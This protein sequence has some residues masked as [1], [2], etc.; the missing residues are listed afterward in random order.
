MRRKGLDEPPSHKRALESEYGSS[1]RHYTLDAIDWNAAVLEVVRAL[2]PVPVYPSH[3]LKDGAAKTHGRR[4]Q[5]EATDTEAWRREGIQRLNEELSRYCKLPEGQTR[6]ECPEMISKG[7]HDHNQ[8][9][10][11]FSLLT[12]SQC[13][14]MLS[15]L[16]DRMRYSSRESLFRSPT[17]LEVTLDRSIYHRHRIVHTLFLISLCL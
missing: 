15:L 16:R 7:E 14:T 6:W 17:L 2:H 9:R 1:L 8:S 3:R 5:G 4:V 12:F 13:S 11:L 10:K